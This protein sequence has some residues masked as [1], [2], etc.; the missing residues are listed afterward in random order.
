MSPE[1]RLLGRALGRVEWKGRR[2]C[3]VAGVLGGAL[4]SARA[5]GRRAREVGVRVRVDAERAA[6]SVG[7][8]ARC[9]VVSGMIERQA[10]ICLWLGSGVAEGV[11]WL[12]GVGVWLRTFEAEGSNGTCKRTAQSAAPTSTLP[13][14]CWLL[15]GPLWIFC[16]GPGLGWPE[17]AHQRTRPGARRGHDSDQA[18]SGR[19]ANQHSAH[20]LKLRLPKAVMQ[21][22]VSERDKYSTAH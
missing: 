8:M 10:H 9:V 22:C 2:D 14:F 3:E 21:R 16:R 11:S 6:R 17:L 15:L 20:Q 19:W 12:R 18:A 4:E 13:G 5:V 1:P 7:A